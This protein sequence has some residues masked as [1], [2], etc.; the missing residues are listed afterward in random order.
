MA[1][2]VESVADFLGVHHIRDATPI[3]SPL[4]RL[5][6]ARIAA[7]G[8]AELWIVERH[9]FRGWEPPPVSPAEAAAV[10]THRASFRQAQAR[11][12]G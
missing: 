11:F 3:G 10:E 12:R 5:R 7:E 2:K 9:G 4:G 1:I 6:K 8:D